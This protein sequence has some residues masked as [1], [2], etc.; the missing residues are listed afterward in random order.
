MT[1]FPVFLLHTNASVDVSLSLFFCEFAYKDVS[2]F[3]FGLG[4]HF[5]QSLCPGDGTS[6]RREASPEQ[7]APR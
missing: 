1:C 7:G 6:D 3:F 2:L 4:C 5:W